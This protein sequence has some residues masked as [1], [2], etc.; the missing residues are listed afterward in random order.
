MFSFLPSTDNYEDPDGP[1]FTGSFAAE[2]S[3]AAYT[4]RLKIVS[5][6]I[7][8]GQNY[9]QAITE[10]QT[11]E[12]LQDVDVL[13]LQEMDEEGTAEMAQALDMN[14]VYYPASVHNQ[15]GRNFGNAIL[16]RWGLSAPQKIILPYKNWYNQQIRIAVRGQVQLPNGQPLLVYAAHTEV[17]AAPRLYR[18]AQIE[19]IVADVQQQPRDIPVVVG[20]DFNTAT[21]RGI[22]RMAAQF[23]TAVLER[24]SKGAGSTVSKFGPTPIAADH[25]FVRGAAVL[26]RGAVTAAQASD[27][28]PVWVQIAM[29]DEPAEKS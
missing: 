1:L 28:Y 4:G 8:F 20:G 19:A 2:P 5:Y 18:Q 14:Y 16:T 10:I 24:A 11:F 15:H 27:H 17:Y 6:N 22:R 26:A 9:A 12:V 7:N 3:P 13:L 21:R 25:L 23:A 29:G